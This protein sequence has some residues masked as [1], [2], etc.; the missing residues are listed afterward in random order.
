MRNSQFDLSGC[1]GDFACLDTAGADLHPASATLRQLHANRLKVGIK[2]PRRPVVSVGDIISELGA[3]AANFATFCHG[4][5]Q[6]PES[7]NQRII[8]KPAHTVSCLGR[9]GNQNL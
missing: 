3:F 8:P 9:N 5:V 2:A 4:F 7:L 6:P 1:F